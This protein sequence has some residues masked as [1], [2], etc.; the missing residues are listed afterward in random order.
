MNDLARPSLYG[1]HHDIRLVRERRMEKRT[2]DVVGPIC[3]SGDHLARE[4]L[5]P[6]VEEGDIICVYDA[7]A[8]GFSM[9]SNYNMRPF[10]REVLVHKGTVNLIR[11]RE[12]IDD[13]LRNQRI[14]SR[15]LL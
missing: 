12:T 6:K 10:P 8:Y 5:L 1:S 4:R 14:P 3:E 11:E 2:V 7:G 9:A 13:L 15:L